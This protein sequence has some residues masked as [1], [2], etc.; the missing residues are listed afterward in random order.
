MKKAILARITVLLM[1]FAVF[2]NFNTC[3]LFTDNIGLGSQVDLTY[4]VISVKED[5]QPGSFLKDTVTIT[6]I[7]TDD[8]GIASVDVTYTFLVKSN[9]ALIKKDESRR[10]YPDPNNNSNYPFVVETVKERME[11]GEFS[12]VATALD[13]EGKVTVT[14]PLIYTVKNNP[15]SLSLQIPRPR[16]HSDGSI[17]NT[18]APSVVTDNYLMGV[19]EDLA[20][21]ASGYPLVKFW[22]ENRPEPTDYKQNTGWEIVTTPP[23]IVSPSKNIGGGWVRADDFAESDMGERGGSI[24]YYLKTRN[25]KGEPNLPDQNG[26]EPGFYKLKMYAEDINGTEMIWPRYLNPD[27][28]K[29]DFNGI[30]FM[31]IEVVAFGIPPQ[32]T[33]EEPK[34]G[35]YYKSD[36]NIKASAEVKGDLDTDIA[37]MCFEI[38]GGFDKHGNKLPI[39]RTQDSGPIIL[40][41][42]D[43][44]ITNKD[45]KTFPVEVGATYYTT[46][47][48]DVAVKLPS[49]YFLSEVEYETYV[50]LTD[51]SYTIGVFARGNAHSK[52]TETRQIYIDRNPPRTDI[53]RVSPVY[54]QDPSVTYYLPSG[55]R[56]E[57]RVFT[58]NKT[59]QIDA[60]ATDTFGSAKDDITGYTKFKYVLFINSDEPG[61]SHSVNHTDNN[62]NGV[63]SREKYILNQIY[64]HSNAKYLDDGKNPAITEGSE[65]VISIK[66]DGGAYTITLR[67]H[68][69]NSA[70]VYNLWLY[71]AA[72]DGAGNPNYQKILLRIDQN[73][74]RPRIAFGN[75]NKQG[76]PHGYT[77]MDDLFYTRFSVLDDNGLA[78][79]SI[80]IRYAV[81]EE[82]RNS[83]GGTSGHWYDL[84]GIPS[85]DHL[86][87][88][89]D[90][91][92]LLKIAC[93]RMNHTHDPL[94][95]S[96]DV[97]HKSSLGA[98]ND[99]KYIMIRA[100][101]DPKTKVYESDGYVYGD[102]EWRPFRLDLT[103][104]K[105]IPSTHDASNSGSASALPVPEGSSA[106]RTDDNPFGS[107][108][109]EVSYKNDLS[110]AYG[111]ITE[112]NLR[113]ITVKINGIEELKYPK[114]I[115]VDELDDN[116]QPTGAKIWVLQ[117]MEDLIINYGG[118]LNNNDEVSVWRGK[119][120]IGWAGELRFRIPIKKY[121]DELP[122]GSHSFE[123]T[124][125]DKA[126]QYDT[127][128]ITIYK[129]ISGP[130]VDLIIPSVKYAANDS[131]NNN[132][133]DTGEVDGENY[134]KLQVNRLRDINAKIIGN[135]SDR[136]SSIFNTGNTEFEYK[137]NNG[138]WI[139]QEIHSPDHNKTLV[140][141]EILL[142]TGLL[143]GT[144][145]LSIRVKDIHG[146][147]TEEKNLVFMLDRSQPKLTITSIKLEEKNVSGVMKQGFTFTGTV[148][149]TFGF[150]NEDF[151]VYVGVD[152]KLKGK[153]VIKKQPIA[154]QDRAFEF[155]YWVRTEDTSRLTYL[156]DFVYGPN[157]I[158]FNVTGSSGQS[159]IATNSITLD[160]K[161]PEVTFNTTGG[162]K[163]TLSGANVNTINTTNA[164][165]WSDNLKVLYDNRVKDRS[166]YA[167]L[168]GR[169]TDE[170]TP[171]P[172]SAGSNSFTFD[173]HISGNSYSESGTITTA[174]SG[175]ES[176]SAG[177]DITI[178]ANMQDG[179]YYLSIHVKDRAGNQSTG[180]D[181]MAFMVDRSIPSISIDIEGGTVPEYDVFSAS[182]MNSKTVTVTVTNTYEVQSHTF[183]VNNAARTAVSSSG[184]KTFTYKYTFTDA[185]G[186]IHG[187]QNI[188]FSATGSSDQTVNAARGFNLD[189]NAPVISIAGKDKVYETQLGS[190]NNVALINTGLDNGAVNPRNWSNISQWGSSISVFN[191]RLRDTTEKLT[192]NFTDDLTPIKTDSLSYRINGAGTWTSLTPIVSDN[193]KVASADIPWSSASYRE[194]LNTLNV[195]IGDTKGNNTL[196]AEYDQN[197]VFMVDMRAPQI[198]DVAG[199]SLNQIYGGN[200]VINISG[201]V[202]NT[203]DVS[204]I[205][206][207]V[208]TVEEQAKGTET[209]TLLDYN[210]AA[211]GFP[212]TL[213]VS[214]NTYND[215]LHGTQSVLINATGT[216]GKTAMQ[217]FNV[218]ID[219]EGPSITFNTTGSPIYMD[220]TNFVSVNNLAYGNNIVN[221]G[222][223]A[224]YDNLR[225]TSVKDVSAKLMG[226]FTDE[227]SSIFA[228]SSGQQGSYWY[229]IDRINAGNTAVSQGTWREVDVTS[230]GSTSVNWQ[231]DLDTIPGQSFPDGLYRISM[232][233]QDRYG[234][235]VAVNGQTSGTASGNVG[236]GY[237]NNMTFLLDRTPPALAADIPVVELGAN[238]K[239]GYKFTGTITNTFDISGFQILAAQNNKLTFVKPTQLTNRSFQYSYWVQTE[240]NIN[241]ALF[242]PD[243]VYGPNTILLSATGSSGQSAMVT[244]SVTLDNKGPEI[245][246]STTG[247]E[248]IELT[249]AN[250]NTINT[251][252]AATWT[253]NNLKILYANRVKDRSALAKL[254]GRFMDD[255]TPIPL[256][257]SSGSISF[258]YEITGENSYHDWG[259]LTASAANADSLSAIWDVPIPQSLPDGIYYLSVHVRDRNGNISTGGEN[260][261]FMV[262]R[263]IPDV[264]I[265]IAGGNN[266]EYDV[267]SA[268]DMTNKTVTVIVTNTYEVQNLSFNINNAAGTT[269]LS[270]GLKTF[271]YTYTFPNAA[272]LNHGL[273][274]IS[275]AAIGSS[276][277]TKNAAL[278]FNLDIN[279]PVISISG[280]NKV[281][282]SELGSNVTSINTSLNSGSI[283]P[284]DW[285]SNLGQVYS[286]RLK[287][288][289]EK[290]TLNFTDDL[291]PIDT[292]SLSYRINSTGT[293]TGLPLSAPLNSK[294]ASV[295]IPWSSAAYRDGLNTLNVRISDTRTNETPSDEYIKNIVFMVDTKVPT[296]IAANGVST[297]E[298]IKVN[299]VFSGNQ[300]IKIKGVVRDVFDVN[301]LGLI[302]NAVEQ[303][304]QGT[305]VD[306]LLE[307]Q[308][309]TPSGNKSGFPFEFDVPTS[310][311][312]HGTQSIIINAIGSS[313]KSAMLSYNIVV[314]KE[315]PSVTFSTTSSPIYV[316]SGDFAAIH[317]YAYG[318]GNINTTQ[319]NEYRL[320][321]AARVTD[322]G[323]RLTGTFTDEHSEIFAPNPVQGNAYGYSYKIDRINAAGNALTEG[324]WV[325][326]HIASPPANN[327]A[328]WQISLD[329]SYTDGL[330]R[331]S[332][333][334]KD[335]L[336]NGDE[337]TVSDSG[338]GYQN[339][340]TFMLDRTP[341]VLSV[342]K[343]NQG[344]GP[345][346]FYKND[347]K[348]VYITGKIFNTFE[349]KG[350]N[351]VVAQD[352]KEIFGNLPTVPGDSTIPSKRTFDYEY[353]VQIEDDTDFV[354]GPNTMVVSATGSSGQSDMK[355]TN[356]I[357]DNRGPEISFNTTGGQKVHLTQGIYDTLNSANIGNGAWD[358][359]RSSVYDTRVKDSSATAKL[360]GRFTDDYT[361]IPDAGTGNYTFRY[362]ITGDSAW[363]SVPSNIEWKSHAMNSSVHDAR[364]VP[365]EIILPVGM[366]DGLYRLSIGVKD[367]GG[368]G[369]SGE[370][371]AA[372]DGTFYGYEA[373]M[374]FMINR[375]TPVL[376]ITD[377]SGSALS[378]DHVFNA[379]NEIA[380][381]G[382]I[383]GTYEVNNFRLTKTDGAIENLIFTQNGPRTFTVSDKVLQEAASS[384]SLKLSHGEQNISFSLTGSSDLAS[385]VPYRFIVDREGPVVEIRGR[386]KIFESGLGSGNTVSSINTGLENGSNP[387]YWSNSL[388]TVFDERMTDTNSKL[389]ITF[390]DNFSAI[391]PGSFEYRINE[392]YGYTPLTIP[393]GNITNNGRNAFVDIP[394]STTPTA[395]NHAYVDGLNKLDIKIRD[396]NTNE[397]TETS[398]VFMVDTQAPILDLI[399]LLQSGQQT[400]IYSGSS[401][402]TVTGIIQN[403]YNVNR[404]DILLG[405][406]EIAALGTDVQ[407]AGEPPEGAVLSGYDSLKG[408]FNFTF[409]LPSASLT[410]GTKSVMISAAGTS[411]KSYMHNVNIII[412]SEGPSI[413][414][415]TA[416][417][418]K[419]NEPIYL[420]DAELAA[421]QGDLSGNELLNGKKGELSGTAIKDQSA[422]LMGNFIDEYSAIFNQNA[423][424]SNEY[425]YYYKI[426][427]LNIDNTISKGSWLWHNVSTPTASTSAGWSISLETD[428]N[429]YGFPFD[430]GYYRLSIRVK[431][432]LNNGYG[433]QK[434][435]Q[436]ADVIPDED[437]NGGDLGYQNNMAFYMERGI[438][439]I[440]ITSAVPS[441]TNK[442]FKIEGEVWNASVNVLSVSLDGSEKY[443]FA[444]GSNAFGFPDNIIVTSLGA[445]N[446]PEIKSRSSF[447]VEILT[448]DLVSE[449]SYPVMITVTGGSGQSNMVAANFTFDK[450]APEAEFRSPTI[451]GNI[452]SDGTLP[453]GSL[454]NNGKYSIVISTGDWFTGETKVG[455]TAE[456]NNGIDK[457]YYRI[458]KL[459]GN[460]RDGAD[461]TARENL[462]ENPGTWLCELCGLASCADSLSVSKKE[463]LDT[464][465]DGDKSGFAKGWTGGLYNWTYTANMNVFENSLLKEEDVD[466]NTSSGDYARAFYMPVYVKIADRAGN[467]NVL[468]YK[469]KV[470]PEADRPKIVF[471]VPE[472]DGKQVGG[473][474][475]V[476]GTATDNEFVHS[477]EIRI[478]TVLLSGETNSHP[479]SGG[480]RFT[481]INGKYYYKNTTDE[482]AYPSNNEGWIKAKLQGIPD[483]FVSWFYSINADSLLSP[484][485]GQLRNVLIEARALDST[486]RLTANNMISRPLERPVIFDSSVPTISTPL[487]RKT[488]MEDQYFF[489]GVRSSERFTVVTNVEDEGGISSI[490]ASQT[491]TSTLTPMVA[492]GQVTNQSGLNDLGWKVTP[493]QTLQ[494]S[495][496][497]ESGWRYYIINPGVNVNWSAID[498]TSDSKA[499][500]AGSMIQ[501][502]GAAKSGLGAVVIKANV[503]DRVAT[504][505]LNNA[506]AA[507]WN[508]QRFRYVLE[509]EINSTSLPG[510]NYGR[511]GS[512]SLNIQVEDNNTGPAG[513]YKANGLYT[514]AID[515]FYPSTT[516]TTHFNASTQNFYISGIARDYL[517]GQSI[518]VQGVSRVL[519]YFSRN[520]TGTFTYKGANLATGLPANTPVYFNPR[521][522]PIGYM[523]T[524]NVFIAFSQTDAFYASGG[525]GNAH[526]GAW[527]TIPAMT[528]TRTN[529]INRDT[530]S[531]TVQPNVSNFP[532]PA[533]AIRAK[534]TNLGNVWESPH[535]MVI[536]SQELG[537]SEDLDVDGTYAEMWAG[538]ADK[539]WQARFDTTNFADGPV[540]VHYIVMDDA[541]NSTH[542][543]KRIYVGNNRPLVRDINLGTDMGRR[544][545]IDAGAATNSTWGK[546]S[547]AIYD[548]DRARGWGDRLEYP[549]TVTT[550]SDTVSTDIYSNT[551]VITTNFRIRNY[552]FNVVLNTLF[553]NGQKRYSVSFVSSR[554]EIQPSAM[555]AGQV[556]TIMQQGNVD[557]RQYGALDGNVGTT[558]V[559]TGTPDASVTGRAYSY[560]LGTG[561]AVKTGNFTA[562]D[563]NNT[564]DKVSNIIF[565]NF[566]GIAD[567]DKDGAGDILQ[568]NRNQKF[569]LIKVYDST[570]TTA[571]ATEQD[572]LSHTFAIALDIDNVDSKRPSISVNPFYWESALKNSLYN[573][574]RN[575]GH[576]E[577]EADLA[578]GTGF[579]ANT[580]IDDLDPKVSGQ[581]SIRGT[582][583]DNNVI[584]QLY[585]RISNNGG[586]TSA[587]F[588]DTAAA[589]TGNNVYQGNGNTWYSAATYS[590]GA[591][592]LVDRFSAA[593]WKFAIE[594]ES[595]NMDGHTINWRLDLDSSFVV[596]TARA[597]NVFSILAKDSVNHSNP[598]AWANNMQTTAAAKTEHY[599]FDVVPYIREVVTPLSL[600][601][602][603]ATSSFNRSA[604][605]W[606]PVRDSKSAAEKIGIKGFNL[607]GPTTSISVNGTALRAI[608]TAVSGD[609]MFVS[610]GTAS[611]PASTLKTHV[612]ARL[613]NDDTFTNDSQIV[614]GAL[615]VTV[616]GMTSLNNR[617]N[618]SAKRITDT[619]TGEVLQYGYNDEPNNINNNI[620]SDDRNMYVW[621]VGSLQN[622]VTGS[623]TL[624]SPSF[625]VSE[626]GRRLMAYAN[627]TAQPGS[628]I[629]ND[630]LAS[631]DTLG[632]VVES[633]INRY[634]YATVALDSGVASGNTAHWYVGGNST[635]ST[636]RTAYNLHSRNQTGYQPNGTNS[637]GNMNPG[638]SKTR[639]LANRLPGADSGSDYTRLK[640]P[641]IHSR[642]TGQNTSRIVMSYGDSMS[643]NNIHLHFGT[644]SGATGTTNPIFSGDFAP[645]AS[646]NT[647]NPA[648]SETIGTQTNGYIP[649][650]MPWPVNAGIGSTTLNQ[651]PNSLTFA[652]A[653]EYA[654]RVQLV[655]DSSQ[656]INATYPY[657]G[658]IYT[659]S[660]SNTNNVPII[661]WYDGT[662]EK[663]LISYGNQV[664]D[665][666][667][668]NANS[669]TE[670]AAWQARATVVQDNAG[671]F[672][673]MAIDGGNNIHLAYYDN[674]GGLCYAYIPASGIP[675]VPSTGTITNV[676]VSGIQTF[677]VD[678]FLSAGLKIMIN[679][680]QETHTASHPSGAGIRYVPYISYYH[681]AFPETKFT[682]RT[683][684]PVRFTGGI[685]A[686]Q[687]TDELDFFT[688]DWEVMT[689][690][691][692][693]LPSSTS[694]FN[695][696]IIANGVPRTSDN[697][698]ELSNTGAST[699]PRRLS[700]YNYTYNQN[701][702]VHKTILV[703]YMTLTHYEGAI[704]KKDLY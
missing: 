33:I 383:T 424:E 577:L 196:P 349:V 669:V 73:T 445:G 665:A 50:T 39:S 138:S 584:E 699:L 329:S 379:N 564:A 572:Q 619:G 549:L 643:N 119:P 700:A 312:S 465:L 251:T 486:D 134:S 583:F 592:T 5:V 410:H 420:S 183:N 377:L 110:F 405:G 580:G 340:M 511:T 573:N 249:A 703:G 608:A 464:G 394:W 389:T 409:V 458:G 195:R 432:R 17:N 348:G 691:V 97:P 274:N 158:L 662:S 155:E 568:A 618:N 417:S 208:N 161:G 642:S 523:N 256:A 212:F 172:S 188:S 314:D 291:S 460:I 526:S 326:E 276:D 165:S 258:D 174:A 306:E 315:G 294:T 667:V 52:H 666:N 452:V 217:N 112:Q 107:P 554:S 131:N 23:P 536:D 589:V 682:V 266:D 365:W 273:Q 678:T 635:T 673:D 470:D 542:S 321:Y 372:I 77:F 697:W 311:F 520:V 184:L 141:W 211:G 652:Q 437:V 539:E 364:S 210:S 553:G 313:G 357:I 579:N 613:D 659:A 182:E 287:D 316:N 290:L 562:T 525:N 547:L 92:N 218:V 336:G 686:G 693:T 599:R 319:Q 601:Y 275:V 31:L 611:N 75:I 590:G 548:Y 41:R 506:A 675:T 485:A 61:A 129:D 162:E 387:I 47:N 234:N 327:F 320:L 179:I 581:V 111:D 404:V 32:I 343:V 78:E 221:A 569:F 101:D 160:N 272:G 237:Q 684:W 616:N 593:G 178:P 83:I 443:R 690:P 531:T 451:G 154:G 481:L 137:I 447:E 403:V 650:T 283:N 157:T 440:K 189:R 64:N 476:T 489:D 491:G 371:I 651:T 24:R 497:W 685:A 263:S 671:P 655:T 209:I 88:S 623:V 82:E 687:G 102:T 324:A 29:D 255:Y 246:F 98:E 224:N 225:K 512:Y 143:D 575:N 9:E 85:E 382:T 411:G 683:A 300:T 374:A 425:G 444:G 467:I 113:S 637:Y 81:N 213:N 524:S 8:Q 68:I 558:F 636:G 116:N 463:W 397:T 656:P 438:P 232:R 190:G 318:T 598:S 74:D 545:A 384:S 480:N 253:D 227:H 604:N 310:S 146:N 57:Y 187:L 472:E 606:Y 91:L 22:P 644:T 704:L 281:F 453:S 679:V 152:Q 393:A 69:Y 402:I 446:D 282:E 204:R 241:P 381:K 148:T 649:P 12:F 265:S 395:L 147:P 117:D 1:V 380:F 640:M 200:D 641:K 191:V 557:W 585:F 269:A 454:S 344:N 457:I 423:A 535:A 66:E 571:G 360:T 230:D 323:G 621:S 530:D 586:S 614:S 164:A 570:V 231:I 252:N 254:S 517:E 413:T 16:M 624:D 355:T 386:E 484:P 133:F 94:T 538:I 615:L 527:A 67:T 559:A 419:T 95:C 305:E 466:G 663:L 293:W 370:A 309:D 361:A 87:I 416:T 609:D 646:A 400:S 244:S 396:N 648:N 72:V 248:K 353:W 192:L 21:V 93:Y 680:R 468:Q 25:E 296:F 177:W 239:K 56:E 271:T 259:T 689:V 36:F 125:E 596:D 473:E 27:G 488:G 328:N 186:L 522:V 26:I 103:K 426:D 235:G 222:T 561:N 7:V 197:I 492:N 284:R 13:I 4:P 84:K 574:S 630:N 120:A 515:N 145:Y 175:T 130:V 433:A 122:D 578:G 469:L 501:Y 304:V 610:S 115:Q 303:K 42:F 167:K 560:A 356:T 166:A 299:E 631:V 695:E 677:R 602:K 245:T 482:W 126:L 563:A 278:G 229:K 502:N 121:I 261:A 30:D 236:H 198:A 600:A 658:S 71:I 434:N 342:E 483:A 153:E 215:L 702:N 429:K 594:S 202:K 503:G 552:A 40:A 369:S 53:T 430:D 106:A 76:S 514:I 375:S 513:A 99:V 194:G 298:G 378:Q 201:V 38:S 479:T 450:T 14:P 363:D 532:F 70:P 228:V 448:S 518:S 439:Q 144:H 140:T 37:E 267:F 366:P 654:A 496:V 170:Y 127:R 638:Q 696:L 302:V 414:F 15:P 670:T 576:I 376:V 543:T 48:S 634:V 325:W 109:K 653:R 597:D 555:V 297:V 350:L 2:M 243:F 455:G 216:S 368:F 330:Y 421:I 436:N 688:G 412:D 20:G 540:N 142:P 44:N 639:V 86:S 333:R 431:D 10:L 627:Y 661:A 352:D 456:D 332:I 428:L 587:A 65:P 462:Y 408:G 317:G 510:L 322:T 471:A 35:D 595:L 268:G 620:L 156:A 529:I 401:P 435:T 603:A 660:A 219:R 508:T 173:W 250:E 341:P 358:S 625:M 385:N 288:T 260:M 390:F 351:I 150:E 220:D 345:I 285:S 701:K 185:T 60:S 139:K 633:T 63:F 692:E 292:A 132:V 617:N 647:T 168:S 19:F 516:M 301:R 58:V 205:S 494:N 528:T 233:V 461:S 59:I 79:D 415:N 28:K 674:N 96:L 18:Y 214:N 104:P 335:R 422:R 181:N 582:S 114:E 541:G 43:T 354:Y 124:I 240:D 169:F 89:I 280:Q 206:L 331:L 499:Y 388:K 136:Y 277:Q 418:D 359:Y 629:L 105:I 672:V 495:D 346:D 546:G 334:V 159:A 149:D 521:G 199:I 490:S 475:R 373:D 398:I 34:A 550:G 62:E 308:G 519:V 51:G 176:T 657:R 238:N 504:V 279:A 664:A 477:V 442:G 534:G 289:A 257:G 264:S 90:N 135:F 3:D 487:I 626:T 556:Y 46:K 339:N 533:Y 459:S 6:L 286:V 551:G 668:R 128:S 337:D 80:Q 449:K 247:G 108:V 295:D 242:A 537:A 123:I 498:A 676:K 607:T 262:D 49:G 694:S 407:Y 565:D 698:V 307:Y 207:L 392:A 605:G 11:D 118:E 591:W 193:D 151:L 681:G 628:L 493:P 632:T 347:K 612:V 45:T 406:N 55:D 180:G 567:S 399:T 622:I 163:I 544:G 427:K 338:K 100:K 203:Y 509:F 367:R 223:N 226:T 362:R 500:G 505:D 441:F 391:T 478:S 566:T 645:A 507:N 474:L 270:S 588:N 54:T 171:I